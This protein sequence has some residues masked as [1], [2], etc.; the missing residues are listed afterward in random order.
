MNHIGMPTTSLIDS[1]NQKDEDGRAKNSI[2]RY[3]SGG[4]RDSSHSLPSRLLRQ[5]R[6]GHE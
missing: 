3:R 2:N 6:R 4:K 5:A 1:G